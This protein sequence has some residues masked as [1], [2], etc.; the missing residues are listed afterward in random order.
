[1]TTVRGARRP[2][3]GDEMDTPEEA[4][5]RGIGGELLEDESLIRDLAE[6]LGGGHHADRDERRKGTDDLDDGRGIIDEDKPWQRSAPADIRETEWWSDSSDEA[7]DDED[8]LE[9]LEGRDLPQDSRDAK[10]MRTMAVEQDLRLDASRACPRVSG[11]A[12]GP[13]RRGVRMVST[14]TYVWSSI[15]EEVGIPF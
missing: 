3:Q 7:G 4:Y 1:M 13:W 9:K 12:T 10:D 14:T 11:C 2:D 6:K 15:L 5:Q 8:W